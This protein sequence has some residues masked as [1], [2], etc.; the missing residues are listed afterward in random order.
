VRPSLSPQAASKILVEHA[1]SRFSTDNLSVM[2]VRFDSKK[3]QSNTSSNIGVERRDSKAKGPSEVETIVNEARRKSGMEDESIAQEEGDSEELK[4]KVMKQIEEEDPEPGP[5]LTP[6]G[7]SD[8]EKV[9]VERS[10]QS[11]QSK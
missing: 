3:L 5:E 10:K 7:L 2:I 8:A 1:L 11:T 4:T 6:E 9:Y